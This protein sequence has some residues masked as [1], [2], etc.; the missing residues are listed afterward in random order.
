MKNA[1]KGSSDRFIFRDLFNYLAEPIFVKDSEHRIVFANR[2]FFDMFKIDEARAIGLTLI[3]AV[4]EHERKHFLTV[5]RHVLDT[6]VGDLREEEL[7]VEGVTR[8]IMTSKQRYTNQAGEHFLVGSIHD[9]TELR[10]VER[11]LQAEKEKLEKAL[12][13]IKTLTGIVPICSYCKKIRN[14]E[15]YWQRI[16]DYLSS[17]S[18]A[19]LSHG[20]CT[21][22]EKKFFPEFDEEG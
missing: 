3:E 10:S 8:T 2:A 1:D 21:E 13:K 7:T 11:E 19:S 6:G 15:G 9:I 18:E 20:I 14:D 5:D 17:H 12:K 22:C 16:E 4:P